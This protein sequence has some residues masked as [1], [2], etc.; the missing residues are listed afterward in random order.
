MDG[1]RAAESPRVASIR[2]SAM[3]LLALLLVSPP[4]DAW[5]AAA[6]KTRTKRGAGGPA[7]CAPLR[8][9]VGGPLPLVA[10]S[11]GAVADF[12]GDGNADF[13]VFDLD[14]MR[15]L[16]ETG[17]GASTPGHPFLRGPARA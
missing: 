6:H 12:D 16:W 15:I 13:A 5:A 7:S 9:P 11:G 3:L 17:R 8:F 1:F 4:P 10:P 14:A 2:R